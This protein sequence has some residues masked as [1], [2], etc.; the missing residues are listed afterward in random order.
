MTRQ[1]GPNRTVRLFAYRQTFDRPD[2]YTNSLVLLT[3]MPT[4]AA[5]LPYVNESG[6]PTPQ[7][8]LI[9]LPLPSQITQI[10]SRFSYPKRLSSAAHRTKVAL[11]SCRSRGAFM[12]AGWRGEGL[13]THKTWRCEHFWQQSTSENTCLRDKQVCKREAKLLYLTESPALSTHAFHQTAHKLVCFE[14]KYLS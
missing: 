10:H 3:S 6:I 14:N 7:S 1:T 12:S 11:S 4:N 5:V 9:T 8:A 13:A 2:N